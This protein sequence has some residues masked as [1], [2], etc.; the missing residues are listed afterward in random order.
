[1][2]LDANNNYVRTTTKPDGVDHKLN[3]KKDAGTSVSE[4]PANVQGNYE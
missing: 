2:D 4:P 3:Q 1:M